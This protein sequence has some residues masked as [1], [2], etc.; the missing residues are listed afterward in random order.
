MNAVRNPDSLEIY[1]ALSLFIDVTD[2]DGINDI[3]SIYLINDENELYWKLTAE[4]WEKKTAGGET[5]LGSNSLLMP[6]GSR[7]PGGEYR[8]L[9]QDTGGDSDERTLAITVPPLNISKLNFPGV[10]VKTGIIT[11]K[12]VRKSYSLWTYSTSGKYINTFT[13]TNKTL[14]I[15]E[16]TQG[17]PIL[18]KG[19]NCYIYTYS[20]RSRYG[21]ISGPYYIEALG[22]GRRNSD[23]RG[24]N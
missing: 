16:L 4:E 2:P 3:E 17:K 21:L 23:S 7:F 8:I 11:I 10:M 22:S 19:F 18:S 20:S 1:Q 5:W 14:K 9:V 12:G 24:S 15:N 6:D 13:L